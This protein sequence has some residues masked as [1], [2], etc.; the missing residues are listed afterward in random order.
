MAELHVRA[1][2]EEAAQAK[3]QFVADL[4]KDCLAAQGQFTIALSGGSTP[5]RL[6]QVLA[7]PPYVSQM[8]WERSS[9]FVVEALSY[10]R[11]GPVAS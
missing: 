3:A 7:A 1:T 9:H 2:T 8:E 4:A 5:R 6:Y 10:S 11:P